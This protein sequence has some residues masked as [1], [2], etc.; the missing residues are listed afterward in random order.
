VSRNVSFFLLKNQI[1]LFKRFLFK[2]TTILGERNSNITDNNNENSADTDPSTVQLFDRHI[3][4]ID[5]VIRR[6]TR[7]TTIDMSSEDMDVDTAADQ[8]PMAAG[9]S[10]DQSANASDIEWRFSQIKGNIEPDEQPADGACVF[11]LFEN[12]ISLFYPMNDST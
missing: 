1:L 2:T 3:S 4:A 10:V 5:Y 12:V 7:A 9:T 11:H 8:S 6:R